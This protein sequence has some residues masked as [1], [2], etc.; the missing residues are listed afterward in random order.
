MLR[1]TNHDQVIHLYKFDFV[2]IHTAPKRTNDTLLALDAL[3]HAVLL[4]LLSLV[5]CTRISYKYD[6]ERSFSFSAQFAH[7]HEKRAALL[8]IFKTKNVP[9]ISHLFVQHG[10]DCFCLL[11]RSPVE[12]A[13]HFV[14]AKKREWIF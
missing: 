10:F 8:N 4:L 9:L 12:W 2:T 13:I 7:T 14:A 6:R 1:K 5:S 3:S 11:F